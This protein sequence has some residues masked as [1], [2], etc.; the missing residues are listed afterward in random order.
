[1]G[2]RLIEQIQV[3]FDF[4]KDTF[5]HHFQHIAYQLLQVKFKAWLHLLIG[6]ENHHL[7]DYLA[8][9]QNDASRPS[10][11]EIS[12]FR[13]IIQDILDNKETESIGSFE[14]CVVNL[15]HLLVLD[16][17]LGVFINKF[18]YCPD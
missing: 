1:M 13:Q 10:L 3:E 16:G 17:E 12:I 18:D 14:V 11:G 8:F 2:G 15:K 4:I 7:L 5:F 9:P 6:K